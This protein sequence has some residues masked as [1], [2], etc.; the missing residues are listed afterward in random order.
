MLT[1]SRAVNACTSSARSDEGSMVCPEIAF[2]TSLGLCRVRPPKNFADTGPSI[3]LMLVA[4]CLGSYKA[5]P[6]RSCLNNLSYIL[7]AGPLQSRVLWLINNTWP[8]TT[9]RV[10]DVQ[11]LLRA[12]VHGAQDAVETAF[13]G[14]YLS[15]HLKLAVSGLQPLGRHSNEFNFSRESIPML[16]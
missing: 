5:F 15:M 2:A 3:L 1:S 8:R 11:V 4:R 6:G 9:C 13:L 10:R 7:R 12:S 14:H 16:S